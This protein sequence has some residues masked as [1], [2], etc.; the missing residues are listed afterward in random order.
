MPVQN[1][2]LAAVLSKLQILSTHTRCPLVQTNIPLSE[3]TNN[4]ITRPR[5]KRPMSLGQAR[6]RVRPKDVQNPRPSNGASSRGLHATREE[7]ADK[8]PH[9]PES[10]PCLPNLPG[11]CLFCLENENKRA[12][13][14][15][16]QLSR[17]LRWPCEARGGNHDTRQAWCNR[18]TPEK[19]PK[20]HVAEL[21]VTT[22]ARTERGVSR[23]GPS[24]QS[25]VVDGAHKANYARVWS[26]TES[27]GCCYVSTLRHVGG[28]K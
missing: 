8:C 28:G 3:H 21:G 11:R 10:R 1:R 26:K 5:A 23:P 2:R 20:G 22:A 17:R 15:N 18:V 6:A 19:H 4:T 24:T 14:D 7:K 25:V 13:D 16:H 12:L 9:L 27:P